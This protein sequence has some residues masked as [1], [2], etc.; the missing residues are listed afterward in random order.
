MNQV[1]FKVTTDLEAAVPRSLDA[2]FAE[3]REW[4][5][6]A[7]E[8][9]RSMAVTEEAVS[10]GKAARAKINKLSKAI[11]DQ[12][13]AVKKRYLEPY[14][15][16]EAQA[17]ELCEI[18]D[19]A[20]G[21]LDR[22]IKEIEERRKQEKLDGLR[23]YFRQRAD[24]AEGCLL[25]EDAFN[26]KWGNAGFS[27]EAAQKEIDEKIATCEAD[28]ATIREMDTPYTAAL[29]ADYLKTHDL[30]AVIRK[31]AELKRLAAEEAKRQAAIEAARKEAEARR[32][33]MER[34]AAETE[35][36]KDETVEI[37]VAVDE[38]DDTPPW[39]VDEP[40]DVTEATEAPADPVIQMDFRVWAT[41][42][43]LAELGK[44]LRDN[45]I[46]YGK[47]V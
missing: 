8:P 19:T 30:A 4:L 6:D 37:E 41:G 12:R 24:Q 40:E 34:K 45:G 10:D 28:I 39:D 13:I 18:C 7:L 23:E 20:S 21:N 32:A 11:S 1:V 2:N 29:L 26:Q 42:A 43:Q 16:F 15:A 17:K 44:Y 5:T 27:V 9:Y 38:D 14:T 31:D 33:E 46:R 47:V 3:V 35:R 25:W 22:Q 36:S